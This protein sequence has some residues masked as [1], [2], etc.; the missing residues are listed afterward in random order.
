MKCREIQSLI[1]PF[2][3]NQLSKDKVL[4]FLEHIE[5]CEECKEE[6][7]VYYILI[8]GL[9][10]LDEEPN[11][12]LDLHGQFLEHLRVTKEHINISRMRRFPKLIILLALLAILLVLLTREL[13]LIPDEKIQNIESQNIGKTIFENN[14][15][16]NLTEIIEDVDR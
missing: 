15:L 13:K 5:H 10:Q 3:N 4:D 1:V 8:I 14:I 11:E 12:T 9:R 7:E 6:L 16:D 2:I